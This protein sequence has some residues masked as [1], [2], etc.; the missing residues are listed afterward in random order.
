M[1]PTFFLSTALMGIPP[2]SPLTE[3]LQ[4][5]TALP[6]YHDA[7]K[8]FSLDVQEVSIPGHPNAWVLRTPEIPVVSIHLAF[9]HAGEKSENKHG[10]CGMIEDLMTAGAGSRDARAFK[11]FLLA[12]NI[13][14]ATNYDQDHFYITLKST[15]QKIDL[16]F[17]VLRDLLLHLRFDKKEI[18]KAIATRMTMLQQSLHSEDSVAQNHLYR[19]AYQQHPY[20]TSIQQVLVTTPTITAQDMRAHMKRFFTKDRLEMVICGN[21]EITDIENRIPTY[22]DALEYHAPELPHPA[23]VPPQLSGDTHTIAMD[24]PQSEIVFYQEGIERHDPDF[25]AAYILNHILIGGGFESRLWNEVREKRGLAYGISARIDSYAHSTL[26]SGS[27]STHHKHVQE[28]IRLI[29]EEWQK[30]YTHGVQEHELQFAQDQ[31]MGALPLRFTQTNQIAA[32]LLTFKLANLEHTYPNKRND[33]I[34]RITLEDINRVAKRLL[35]PDK[36]SFIV[37]GRTQTPP[38]LE[39]SE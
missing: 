20:G 35:T 11:R 17:E 8:G 37:V 24:I 10:V 6:A 14:I 9:R 15:D 27:T 18:A 29:Q 1:L 25:M 21:I 4:T 38:S 36:L 22:L 12:E 3:E 13:R 16:L 23:Y 39:T 34:H 30:V 33:L 7:L 2:Q 32:H 28:V 31:L 5:E 26:W 19:A